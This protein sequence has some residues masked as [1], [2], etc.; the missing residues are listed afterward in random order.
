MVVSFLLGVTLA[1]TLVLFVGT[2]AG[3]W[4]MV[5]LRWWKHK[6][7]PSLNWEQFSLGIQ[8][9]CWLLLALGLFIVEFAP[10]GA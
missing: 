2:Q 8:F 5:R 6:V 3:Q 1:Y 9:G 4:C 7:C 10:L